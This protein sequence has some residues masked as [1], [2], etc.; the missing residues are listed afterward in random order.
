MPAKLA[1][2]VNEHSV[3]LRRLAG[4]IADRIACREMTVLLAEREP[5]AIAMLALEHEVSEEQ[6]EAA[7]N[8]IAL[9]R[10]SNIPGWITGE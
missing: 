10:K 7:L 5:Y 6:V 1:Q 8:Y 3:E 2:L 9:V 4:T